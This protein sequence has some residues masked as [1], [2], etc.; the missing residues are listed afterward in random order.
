MMLWA[1]LGLGTVFLVA[2]IRTLNDLPKHQLD[3]SADP[4]A[5]P[6]RHT[7][8]RLDLLRADGYTPEGQSIL[9]RYLV[10]LVLWFLAWFAALCIYVLRDV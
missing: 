9:R 2:G 5:F 10:L 8:N 6:D 7:F 3:K 1:L 4:T